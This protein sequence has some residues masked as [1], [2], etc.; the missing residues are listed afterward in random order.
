MHL[1]VP[2]T[3]VSASAEP[4]EGCGVV[5]VPG[6]ASAARY[7]QWLAALAQALE[8]ARVLVRLLEGEG[9]YEEIA[10]LRNLIEEIRAEVRELRLGRSV[11][12]GALSPKWTKSLPWHSDPAERR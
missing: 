11:L 3:A 6:G 4:T 9:R 2:G 12:V 10:E 1:S 5:G 8:D 7:A